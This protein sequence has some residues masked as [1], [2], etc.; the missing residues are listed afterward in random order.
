MTQRK[1]EMGLIENFISFILKVL[2]DV[3]N[4]ECATMFYE[5]LVI[6]FSGLSRTFKI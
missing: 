3:W 6:A 4:S 5:T 1:L 2:D